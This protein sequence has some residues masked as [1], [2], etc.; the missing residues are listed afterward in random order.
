MDTC[1]PAGMTVRR[2]NSMW[3]LV[4]I[5][6]LL[7]S[8]SVHSQAIVDDTNQPIDVYPIA[9]RIITL[10]PHTTDIMLAIGGEHKLIAAASYSSNL[11]EH[12]LR[13]ATLGGI[14]REQIL[15]LQPDLIIAWASGNRASDLAW[16]TQ[17]KIR[18]FHS[19]PK[20][21]QQLADSIRAIG[22]LV[23]KNEQANTVSEQFMQSIRNAC[24]KPTQ[25]TAYLSIWD[26]PAM[27]VG[28]KHWM[29]DVLRY[30]GLV[31]SYQTVDRGIFSVEAESLAKQQN[32]KRIDTQ[33]IPD[34][35]LSRPGPQLVE[36]VRYLCAR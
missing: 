36:A 32:I 7:T 19:E 24:D 18:V 30:A 20:T 34:N 29:N 9:T 15:E 4:S 22:K 21:L 33:N 25:Q 14:D 6:L 17:Q 5:G 3:L 11:P 12:I 35:A 16:L 2:N 8:F 31:N 28:G 13:V 26:K 1:F 27:T 23:G 10:S